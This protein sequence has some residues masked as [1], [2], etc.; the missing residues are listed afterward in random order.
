MSFA[1]KFHDAMA[2]CSEGSEERLAEIKKHIVKP[3]EAKDPE[4]IAF[5]F[6][7]NSSIEMHQREDGGF[8]SEIT[9]IKGIYPIP[10]PEVK[11]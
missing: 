11:H 7:D 5:L 3:L 9:E 6:D 8:D 1:E 10:D 4:N 2:D